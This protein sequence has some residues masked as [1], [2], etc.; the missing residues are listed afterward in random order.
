MARDT[1]GKRRAQRKA[2]QGAAE[3]VPLEAARMR[4]LG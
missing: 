2:A 4:L 3:A 1:R